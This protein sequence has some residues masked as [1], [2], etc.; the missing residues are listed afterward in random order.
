MR[1]PL[2]ALLFFFTSLCSCNLSNNTKD[3]NEGDPNSEQESLEFQKLRK[4]QDSL[5]ELKQNNPKKKG[6]DSL[7]PIQA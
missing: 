6:L 3:T 4:K 5:L 2:V 7:K 1:F